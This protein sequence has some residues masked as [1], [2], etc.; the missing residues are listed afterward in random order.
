MFLVAN[1]ASYGPVRLLDKERVNKW[2]FLRVGWC[3]VPMLLSTAAA[4]T[5]NRRIANILLRI[6][7]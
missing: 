4:V 6:G 2:L 7:F 3:I 5:T 1:I